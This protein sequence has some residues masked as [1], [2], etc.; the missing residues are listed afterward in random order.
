MRS[1]STTRTPLVALPWLA[2]VDDPELDEREPATFPEHELSKP[3]R[4]LL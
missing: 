4:G 3:R 2:V 1:S